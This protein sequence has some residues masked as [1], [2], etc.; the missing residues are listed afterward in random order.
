[1]PPN[2]MITHIVNTP[3]EKHN[4]PCFPPVFPTTP[5]I[6]TPQQ[7]NKNMPIITSIEPLDL[8]KQ[9]SPSKHAPS[10]PWPQ[11]QIEPVTE[12]SKT[13]QVYVHPLVKRSSS[14][15][16]LK[17]LEMCTE[18]LG[19]ETGNDMISN[20][21]EFYHQH[22][23]EK[24]SCNRKNQESPKKIKK[25]INFPPPLTS[26]SGNEGVQVKTHREDGR[27][28]IKAF[29]FSCCR[30]YFQAERENGRLK[31]S[32]LR[33]SENDEPS[34]NEEEEV[35]KENVNDNEDDLNGSYFDEP[36]S[37]GADDGGKIGS[38]IN[39]GDWSGGGRCN[40]DRSSRSNSLPSLPFCVAIS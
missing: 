34:D 13:E 31:L 8:T 15:L 37:N 17:S 5:N 2:P 10:F 4:L 35:E 16:S 1:M 7:N 9:L 21:D 38:K 19:S 18:S 23:L 30:N 36:E 3:I 14:S 26:I 24:Q 32:F 6:T 22:A 11:K 27:L 33:H 25:A 12:N 39:G 29:S 20:I 28:V 40:G